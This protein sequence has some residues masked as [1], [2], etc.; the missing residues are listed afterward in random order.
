MGYICS[1]MDILKGRERGDDD[2]NDDAMKREKSALYAR[3]RHGIFGYE[4]PFG[5]AHHLSS[6]SQRGAALRRDFATQLQGGV[7][8]STSYSTYQ[9]NTSSLQQH[10]HPAFLS[11]HSSTRQKCPRREVLVHLL[12]AIILLQTRFLFLL[13]PPYDSKPS[14]HVRP[15][16]LPRGQVSVSSTSV[17]RRKGHQSDELLGT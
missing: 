7:C 16:G 9:S 13:S 3:C 12:Q 11:F 10:P 8:Q 1:S 5:P 14:R 2:D 15:Q 17:S 4:L 6:A